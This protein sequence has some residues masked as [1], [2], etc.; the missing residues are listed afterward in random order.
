MWTSLISVRYHCVSF[1]AENIAIQLRKRKKH[2]RYIHMMKR[3]LTDTLPKYYFK[4]GMG[5]IYTIK[6]SINGK[7]NGRN[8]T[9]NHIFLKKIKDKQYPRTH[10]LYLYANY[11]FREV[12]SRYGL[13]A[14][15]IWFFRV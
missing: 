13:F 9:I 14:V 11:G 4:Y 10:Q 12:L 8:R 2:W 1:L 15:K 6:V 3:L 7:I 5:E